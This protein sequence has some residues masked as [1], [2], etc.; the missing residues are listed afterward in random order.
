MKAGVLVVDFLISIH[1][2]R[3]EGDCGTRTLSNS[4]EKFQSTP[5]A[6]RETPRRRRGEEKPVI[7][8][9]SLRMEGDP[10]SSG[11]SRT[12]GISIHSLRMEGDKTN[13]EIVGLSDI[14]IHSL[15]MEGDNRKFIR[16][17]LLVKISIHS[18]RMEGDF[19]CTV[20]AICQIHIS[21]HSLRME[22]DYSIPINLIVLRDFN[23]LPPH[24]GRLHAAAVVGT[25]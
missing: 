13:A 22:G 5:S 12:G 10:S 7:S 20:N 11:R 3:M 23:P 18:L 21:I 25:L 4:V 6:W 16:L 9:H 2:L 8:I 24:G 14:S 17:L 19:T 1:S 15:R